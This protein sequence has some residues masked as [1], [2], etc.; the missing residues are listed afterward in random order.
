MNDSVLNSV[1]DSVRNSV[2]NSVT[3]SVYNKLKTY[4]FAKRNEGFY[5]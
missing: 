2:Y 1:Y 5:K 3:N 4:N